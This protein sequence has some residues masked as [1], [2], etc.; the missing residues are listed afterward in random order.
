MTNQNFVNPLVA[1]GYPT[2]AGSEELMRQLQ[3]LDE[4]LIRWLAQIEPCVATWWPV[5]LFTRVPPEGEIRRR[6][7]ENF[8]T[9][10]LF[11]FNIHYERDSPSP[12]R[13]RR[14][15]IPS[16]SRSYF[17]SFLPQSSAY[18]NHALDAN[19]P[20]DALLWH[21]D[22]GQFFASCFRVMHFETSQ[23]AREVDRALMESQAQ[24]QTESQTAE[25]AA[26]LK[27]LWEEKF[28]GK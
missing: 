18:F 4:C 23:V 1:V 10:N 2:T 16:D 8:R 20:Q 11:G 14:Y 24:S 25:Q 28:K 13:A 22:V 5:E 6:W 17:E 26:H 9:L 27:N 15:Y 7:E 3:R 19:P 12:W 21:R